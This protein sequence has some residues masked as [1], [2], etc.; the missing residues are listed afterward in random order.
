[1]YPD[2]SFRIVKVLF[3][4]YKELGP[5]HQEKYYQR[6]TALGLTNEK[7]K[8][9]EQLYVPLVFRGVKIGKNFLDFLVED[10]IVLELKKGEF[11]PSIIYQQVEEYLRSINKPLAIV[12]NFTSKGV[13][14]KRVINK[15]YK[16][17]S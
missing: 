13:R 9:K 6:A 2:L 14:Y 12:A 3:E 10:V 7:L 5:G 17:I 15:D 16:D 1:M 4:V 8:H 11:V